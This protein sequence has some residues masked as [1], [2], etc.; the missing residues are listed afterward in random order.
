[1]ENPSPNVAMVF[2]ALGD[3]TRRT[4]L[5]H[6]GNG[7]ASVSGLAAPLG[8]TLAAVVQHVQVLEDSGLVSTQKTGRV[9]ICT[10]NPAGLAVAEQWLRARR[11]AWET[12]L[13]RLGDLLAETS[14]KPSA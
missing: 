13:D 6:L 11:P 3:P 4:I 8:I 12:R 5:E 1:M 10:I 14:V 7:P 9:R 2:Q